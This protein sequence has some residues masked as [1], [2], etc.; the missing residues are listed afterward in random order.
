MK[1]LSF[2]NLLFISV[3]TSMTALCVILE[4]L[5]V[6]KYILIGLFFILVVKNFNYNKFK[7][8][9]ITNANLFLVIAIYLGIA[10]MSTRPSL[11]MAFDFTSNQSNTLSGQTTSILNQIK[12]KNEIINIRSYFTDH[13]KEKKFRSLINLMRLENSDLRVTYLD[14]IDNSLEARKDLITKANAVVVQIS[15][16]TKKV[17]NPNEKTISEALLSLL[18]WKKKKIFF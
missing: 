9:I 6:I 12:S 14:P 3:F 5:A 11:N 7:T 4:N 2:R 13:K 16:R 1:F 17:D 10:M 8:N 15:D 18:N